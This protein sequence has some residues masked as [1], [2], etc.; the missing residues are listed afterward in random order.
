MSLSNYLN[1]TKPESSLR[2]NLFLVT[3]PSAITV[4]TLG[5]HIL[6]IT[7]HPVYVVRITPLV[8]ITRDI[9][10]GEMA[11]FIGA[12]GIFIF[13][14]WYGKKINK[15]SENDSPV[16][17]ASSSSTTKTTETTETKNA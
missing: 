7:I 10:W 12:F 1:G 6:W 13:Q 11:A 4:L 17:G 2:L 15:D 5:I 16:D 8:Y 3:V 14:L 9:H